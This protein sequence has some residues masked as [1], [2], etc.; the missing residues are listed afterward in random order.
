[1]TTLPAMPSGPAAPSRLVA[2]VTTHCNLH[3]PDC[4]R[5]APGS[6]VMDGNM[7][8]ETFRAL[9]PV[10]PGLDFLVL[11]GLGEPLLHPDLEGFIRFA[12]ERMRPGAG[13][14]IQTNGLLL[15]PQRAASLARAGLDTLCLSVDSLRPD[16]L[17]GL[18]G[19]TRPRDLERAMAAARAGGFGRGGLR[20]G[21]EF[22]LRRDTLGELPG[23]VEWCGGQGCAFLLVT[24]LLPYGAQA[25]AQSLFN[26]HCAAARDIF[27]RYRAQ[28]AAEGLDLA[29]YL[30]P[31]LKYAK[32]PGEERL[33]ELVKAMLSEAAGQGVMLNLA[34]LLAWERRSVPDLEAGFARAREAAA[35]LGLD[36]A[37]PAAATPR[38]RECRFVESGALFVG[39]DGD[40]HPCPFLWHPLGCSLAGEDRRVRPVTF[41]NV[42][43][44]S[45][46]DIWQAEA[47]RSFR[48]EA[49]AYDYP[50]C[51]DCAVAPCDD[52]RGGAVAFEADC[53]GSAVPCGHCPWPLG[54]FS[55]LS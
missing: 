29:G 11:T 32:S 27:A 30:R 6:R 25:E 24:H 43:L 12:R 44:A 40:A 8:P 54:G 28:A 42:A 36:L 4:P 2:E 38:R 35:R 53:F 16:L 13:I 21:A 23:V 52:I 19:G 55:C 37:L 9:A 47:C 10:L 5:Q 3:C 14:G 1:M 50:Y 51:A 46:A 26:P 20:L 39:R 34:G 17:P 45:P 48:Q 41:G 18:R 15:T 22:V 33:G 49:L 31:L 7:S